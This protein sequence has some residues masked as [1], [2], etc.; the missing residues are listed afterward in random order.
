[1]AILLCLCIASGT[2]VGCGKEE[3]LDK[4]YNP[5]QVTLS[6]S[7]SKEGKKSVATDFLG[8][9][10]CLVPQN[11]VL[12]NGLDNTYIKGAGA[13]NIS[14]GETQYAYHA[15]DKCY[16]A[17]TTKILTAHLVLKYGK[18]K[19]K[20]IISKNATM[21]PPGAM[22]AGLVEGDEVT[23]ENL[24]YGLMFVSGNDAAIALAEYVSGTVEEFAKLMNEEAKELGA[25]SS[26]FV[27]PNGIHD[28][29]H[30][31]T[32]YD[33]YLI[34]DAAFKDVT[35]QKIIKTKKKTVKIQS[36]NGTIRKQTYKNG[37]RFL[38]NKVNIPETYKV[39]GG[40]SGTTYK[41]GKCFI[42]FTED[43]KKDNRILI[44]MGADT[45]EHLD[46]FMSGLMEK[47]QEINKK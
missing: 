32:V 16:P 39:L 4:P 7:T 12:L 25:T 30:Y 26:H 13:F 22:S 15:L 10:I 21:L 34:S 19:D 23:V 36:V 8:S 43:K 5:Y 18:L 24:L 38:Q 11:D 2:L 3:A 27:N 35:F 1:M 47:I 40:K 9:E 42:L 37:N 17:S 20:V 6:D 44:V 46:V 14:T 28:D 31:S 33:M 45:S 29:E 41:A